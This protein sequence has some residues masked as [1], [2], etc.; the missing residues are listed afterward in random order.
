MRSIPVWLEIQI[1]CCITSCRKML[2]GIT[3]ESV[4]FIECD[5]RKQDGGGLQYDALE[6]H[7][8]RPCQSV[9]KQAASPTASASLGIQIHFT[10]F[11]D[12][13]SNTIKADR[14]DNLPRFVN[15]KVERPAARKIARLDIDEI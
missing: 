15:K 11:T 7:L 6:A 10:K 8:G 5:G 12:R 9:F 2:R 13:V 3:L 4:T 1:I 14:P